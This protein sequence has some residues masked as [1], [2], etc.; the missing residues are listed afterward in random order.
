M[1]FVEVVRPSLCQLVAGN[2]AD[3]KSRQN[4]DERKQIGA[5]FDDE[6]AEAIEKEDFSGGIRRAR[7]R[8]IESSAGSSVMA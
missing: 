1:A 6:G 8:R 5:A 2:A 4:R 3:E 7:S